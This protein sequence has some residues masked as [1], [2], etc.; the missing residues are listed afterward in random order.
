MCKSSSV[1]PEKESSVVN[2]STKF[3][4]VSTGFHVLELHLP[5]LGAG[6]VWLIILLLLIAMIIFLHRRCQRRWTRR[7]PSNALGASHFQHG[8]L[9]SLPTVSYIGLRQQGPALP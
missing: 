4:E 1:Q 5:T 3:T 8:K 6:F 2:Q 9:S 7:L